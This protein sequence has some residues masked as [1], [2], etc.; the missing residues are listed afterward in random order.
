MYYKKV[1]LLTELVGAYIL[2]GLAVG[3]F[4]LMW[5]PCVNDILF[6]LLRITL[7]TFLICCL[8]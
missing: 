7:T 1:K 4:R 6:I 2:L 3:L 5:H 8:S